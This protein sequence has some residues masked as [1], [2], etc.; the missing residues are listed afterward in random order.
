MAEFV[1]SVQTRSGRDE[2]SEMSSNAARKSTSTTVSSSRETDKSRTSGGKIVA[3]RQKNEKAKAPD[4]GDLLNLLPHAVF[5]KDRDG[6]FLGVNRK[7]AHDMG[8]DDPDEV[9]GK[10]DDDMPHFSREEVT[11]FRKCDLEVMQTGE[12]IHDI[13]ESQGREGGRRSRL[14]T[15]KYPLKNS[16]G[17]IIGI[18][19][20]YLDVEEELS[21]SE[22]VDGFAKFR[23]QLADPL[24]AIL[25]SATLGLRLSGDDERSRAVFQ[26]ILDHATRAK[27]LLEK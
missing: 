25:L 2:T 12:P 21:E 24:T 13:E 20:T 27:K 10:T 7:C 22:Q 26:T 11:F 23:H 8:F 3:L 14:L 1:L 19:G 4:A 16:T 17:D 15:F 18:W 9:I 6:R 5:W